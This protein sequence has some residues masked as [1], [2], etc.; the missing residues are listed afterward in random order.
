MQVHINKYRKRTHGLSYMV[1]L[2]INFFGFTLLP[3]GFV[4]TLVDP[5]GLL[6]D[7]F[8]QFILS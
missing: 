2:V 5:V 3:I 4:F 6:P 1:C 8:S 7:Y